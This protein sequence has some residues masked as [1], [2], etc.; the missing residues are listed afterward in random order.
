VPQQFKTLVIEQMLDVVPCAGEEI[1]HAEHLAAALQ[2]LLAEMRPEKPSSARNK[3]ASLKMLHRIPYP[4]ATAQFQAT[5]HHS[6][7]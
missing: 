1:I 6:N 5:Q 2:E 3:D 4:L 7:S